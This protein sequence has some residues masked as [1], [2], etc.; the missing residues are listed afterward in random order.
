M[1]VP[2]RVWESD[3]CH[4]MYIS[5]TFYCS[6]WIMVC[7][8]F[9]SRWIRGD[10]KQWT[11]QSQLASSASESTTPAQRS[12]L[13]TS[14]LCPISWGQWRA[15]PKLSLTPNSFWMAG[16]WTSFK[17]GSEMESK[18][19]GCVCACACVESFVFVFV[20]KWLSVMWWLCIFKLDNGMVRCFCLSSDFVPRLSTQF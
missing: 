17:G 10:L 9:A 19:G 13:L 12:S 5:S 1:C 16:V 4:S 6:K 14:S 2:P 7:T 15:L 20:T 18:G 8:V 11:V 3:Y